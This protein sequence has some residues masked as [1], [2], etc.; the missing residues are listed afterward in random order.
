MAMC[1]VYARFIV[2]VLLWHCLRLIVLGSQII[3]DIPWDV[4]FLATQTLERREVLFS[5][6]IRGGAGCD[7]R[8][9]SIRLGGEK[10]YPLLTRT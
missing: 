2:I 9:E 10:L 4:S 1:I 8:A 3:S 5:L 7:S 6:S